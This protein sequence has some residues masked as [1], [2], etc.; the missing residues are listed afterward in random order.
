MTNAKEFNFQICHEQVTPEGGYKN[1]Y[2]IEDLT[3]YGVWGYLQEWRTSRFAP[4]QV[5]FEIEIGDET[6]YE[7][8]FLNADSPRARAFYNKLLRCI[9]AGN[10]AE[11]LDNV[12]EVKFRPDTVMNDV[13]KRHFN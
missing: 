11:F 9:E 4:E 12:I 2:H 7:V 3:G 5:T 1:T 13:I 6:A 8:H 10:F